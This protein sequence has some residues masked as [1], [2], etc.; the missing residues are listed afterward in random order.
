[1]LKTMGANCR[2]NP[3]QDEYSSFL[4]S[5]N[6]GFTKRN[7]QSCQGKRRSFP[8]LKYKAYIILTCTT[9][10]DNGLNLKPLTL[11][12]WIIDNYLI[13]LFIITYTIMDN[14]FERH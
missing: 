13:Q 3:H 12:T 7:A 5:C 14:T 1:M 4:A 10:C 6:V 8:K 11:K 2:V 9:S